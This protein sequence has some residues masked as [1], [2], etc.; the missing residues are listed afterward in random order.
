MRSVSTNLEIISLRSIKRLVFMTEM[1]CAFCAVQLYDHGFRPRATQLTN[2]YSISSTGNRV[3]SSLQCPHILC[4]TSKISGGGGGEILP[5]WLS[6]WVEG[7]LIIHSC[8]VPRLRMRG[9]LPSHPTHIHGL[10]LKETQRSSSL[11]GDL[12]A[13]KGI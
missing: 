11:A 8:L 7:R 2:W 3:L 4:F 1:Q 6:G 5:G 12:L 10:I 9:A 13:S